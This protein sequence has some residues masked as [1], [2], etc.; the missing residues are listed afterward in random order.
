MTGTG[1][2]WRFAA[3]VRIR[4]VSTALL[5]ALAAGCAV[6]LMATSAWLIARAAQQP[7]VLFLMVAIVMVRAFGVGRGALRYAERLV[8]HDAVLRVLSRL[9]EAVMAALAELAPAGLPVWRRG[10]LLARLTDDIDD[11]GDG[12]LRGLLPIATGLAVGAGTIGL[13]M[14]V[15][16]AAGWLL[17]VALAVACL[18]VPVAARRSVAGIEEAAVARRGDRSRLLGEL[19]DQLGEVSAAG[20]LPDR[21]AELDRVDGGLRRSRARVARIDGVAAGV[22]VLVTG[23]AVAGAALV[24]VDA[25]RQGRLDPVWL[26]VLMLTP[27]ALADLVQAVGSGFAAL[28]RAG[29]AAR[30]IQAVLRAGSLECDSPGPAG[31]RQVPATPVIELRGVSA[32]WP[33]QRRDALREVDLMLRP[34][35]R[36]VVVGES[37]S[38]KSTLLAVLLGFL[39]PTAGR[40]LVDGIDAGEFDPEELRRL[41]GWCEQQTYLFDSSVAENVRLARPQSSDEEVAATLRRAGLGDWLDRL[42]AGLA[43]GVGEHGVGVSGG[44]R[45]RIGIAR[46]LLAGRPFLLADEPTAHLDPATADAITRLL[47]RPDPLRATVLVTHREAD[48]ALGTAVLRLSAQPD[49]TDLPLSLD[50]H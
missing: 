12:F 7:P 5:G 34:G 13:S 41:F 15:L 44:E 48:V 33:G 20:V 11:V 21:L 35:D 50:T 37:G 1:L 14:A 22:A 9:R 16:P 28:D 19:F 24:G 38:G 10:D 45:Q 43:T 29:V 49:R 17:M 4:M 18:V 2:L 40:Y 42:P 32:R 36:L 31:W 26:A 8:G 6:A 30:R 25:V 39:R 3:G 23:L 46:A 47:M 27:L